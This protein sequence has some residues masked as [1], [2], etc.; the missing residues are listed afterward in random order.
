MLYLVIDIS[1]NGESEVAN[2]TVNSDWNTEE[3]V[4]AQI[5]IV[6]ISAGYTG[7]PEILTVAPRG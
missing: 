3:D 5:S 6:R 2:R 7:S 1:Q 4:L